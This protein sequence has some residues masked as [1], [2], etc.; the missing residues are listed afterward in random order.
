MC[1]SIFFPGCRLCVLVFIDFT[2]SVMLCNLW[3]VLL[4][5]YH[6]LVPRLLTF[7]HIVERINVEYTTWAR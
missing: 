5:N 7:I 1:H 4:R 6:G 2:D 3:K